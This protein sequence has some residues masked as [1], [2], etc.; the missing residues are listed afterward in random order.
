IDCFSWDSLLII[1]PAFGKERVEKYSGIELPSGVNYSWVTDGE[2]S[3]WFILFINNNEV[4]DY[5]PIKRTDLDFSLLRRNV[6]KTPEDFFFVSKDK[7]VF[8]TYSS[9]ERFFNSVEEVTW[10]RFCK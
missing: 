5:F 7:A 8:F 3:E 4:I 6:I 9:G 10:A 2:G 1:A